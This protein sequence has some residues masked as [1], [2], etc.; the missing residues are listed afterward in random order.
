MAYDADNRLTS[1]AGTPTTLDNGA[2]LHI[3][4][5]LLGHARLDTTQIYTHVSIAQLREVPARCHP[6]GQA[7]TTA[8]LLDGT[9]PATSQP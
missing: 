9:K 8:D 2:D 5:E 1:A 4:Q 3:I 6:R 7:K